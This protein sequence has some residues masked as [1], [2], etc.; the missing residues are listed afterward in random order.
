MIEELFKELP[1]SQIDIKL[2]MD[3][4]ERGLEVDYVV[5]GYDEWGNKLH[6]SS[7][8]AETIEDAMKIIQ[9]DLQV[10][11]NIIYGVS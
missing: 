8:I 11:A 6:L 3:M 2:S 10:K 4:G 7:G 1:Y 9:G 5:E